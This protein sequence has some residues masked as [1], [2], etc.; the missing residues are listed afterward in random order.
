M[1][2]LLQDPTYEHLPVVSI[3]G[4]ALRNRS[5]VASLYT[6]YKYA[7]LFGIQKEEIRKLV[8]TVGLITSYPNA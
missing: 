3:A 6:W 4:L 8:K 2:K 5:V 7:R 1:K